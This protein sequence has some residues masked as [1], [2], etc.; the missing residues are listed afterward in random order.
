MK[1]I[2]LIK[3]A[4]FGIRK[5]HFSKLRAVL[6]DMKNNG[7]RT[8]AKKLDDTHPGIA[9]TQRLFKNKKGHGFSFFG[10][11]PDELKSRFT[12]NKNYFKTANK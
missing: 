6:T 2:I 9:K 11:D 1:K 7:Y 12:G 8:V 4:L 3:T 5:E 10:T